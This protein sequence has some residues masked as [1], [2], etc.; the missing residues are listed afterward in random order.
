MLSRLLITGNISNG[1]PLCVLLEIADAHGISYDDEILDDPEFINIL[2]YN[3]YLESKNIPNIKYPI[4]RLDDWKY[5]ARFVNKHISWR[6]DKLIAAYEYLIK[7]MNDDNV[8]DKIPINFTYGLQTSENLYSVNSCVLYKICRFHNINITSKTKMD[9]MYQAINYLRMDINVLISKSKLFIEKHA[10]SSDLINI[11]ISNNNPKNNDNNYNS[12]IDIKYLPNSITKYDSLAKLYKT[13]TSI[14]DLQRRVLPSTDEGSIALAA[15]N[16]ATDISKSQCPLE[17]YE[18]L[19]TQKIVYEPIDPWLKYWYLENPDLFNLSKTFNPLF[20]QSFYSKEQ[21]FGLAKKEGYN[22]KEL[23]KN[24]HYELMQLAYIS[25]TFYTGP[26]PRI[27][28]DITIID[29]DKL[30]EIPHGQ[31][32]CYGQMEILLYPISI[33]ELIDLFTA[34]QN[35]TSPFEANKIFSLTSINKLKNI[36]I[37]P[38]GP[39]PKIKID[40]ETL[41]IRKKLLDIIADIQL[42]NEDESTSNLVTTYKKS[43]SSTKL[44][45]KKLLNIILELGMYMRG[46]LGTEQYPVEE[47]VVL[48]ENEPTVAVNVTD[49]ITD[50]EKM[51]ESLGKIGTLMDNLPLVKYKDGEYQTSS[52]I[53]DGF[54]IGERIRIIKNGYKNKSVHSCIRMSSNWICSCAHKY[55]QALGFPP[56]FDIFKLRYI[57]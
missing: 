45:I 4:T 42:F 37:Y 18:I 20:P 10:T 31:L 44:S 55:I 30:L 9:Q 23:S 41:N 21:L 13:L 1:A 19:R 34:N 49:A 47:S 43:D 46:W 56:P 25:D 17:E 36:L 2:V 15:I 29:L 38:H 39:N 54:T 3:I 33:S 53:K 40:S 22:E 14:K 48:H 28:G 8:L 35:F 27:K 51:I 24:N 16:Y 57:S 5:L 11:L 52:S 12:P 26:L 7:F 6:Q 32:L 50:Y